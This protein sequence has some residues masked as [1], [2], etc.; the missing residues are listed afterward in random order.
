M[1]QQPP[2]RQPTLDVIRGGA[3][4]SPI[5][6]TSVGGF[7]AMAASPAWPAVSTG[8]A[9]QAVTMTATATQLE[10]ASCAAPAVGEPMVAEAAQEP[11]AEAMPQAAES[12]APAFEA[13]A[14]A[15]GNFIPPR[16]TESFA[17]PAPQSAPAPQPAAE[18]PAPAAAAGDKKRSFSLFE[19]VTGAARR[20][21]NAV[22]QAV[23]QPAPQGERAMPTFGA[24]VASRPQQPETT[25]IP[26]GQPRLGIDAPAKAK[27]SSPEDDLLEI[28]AFLRRQAN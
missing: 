10:P 7:S 3:D 15:A 25:M 26:M 2:V 21:E 12:V 4:T 5:R 28:P 13:P 16:P 22:T 14:E 11:A 8:M 9:A 27:A 17:R 6:K 18:Q 1:V 19:R 20:A 23:H 24:R